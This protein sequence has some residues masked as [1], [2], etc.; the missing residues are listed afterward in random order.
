VKATVPVA[1]PLTL[2]VQAVFCEPYVI[3]F[4]LH[5]TEILGVALLMTTVTGVALTLLLFA[6]PL[7]V[8]VMT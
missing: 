4:G 6:S 5:E 2:A 7:Y 3:G 1:P 8:A